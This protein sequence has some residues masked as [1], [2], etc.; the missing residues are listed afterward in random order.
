M[1]FRRRF[2]FPLFIG[3]LLFTVS[4]DAL[5]IFGGGP[6]CTLMGCSEGIN[7]VLTGEVPE[8]YFINTGLTEANA[9]LP[10][11]RQILSCKL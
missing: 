4:C 10:A 1:I 6:V 2:N 3:V 8:S 11:C 5:D 9:L 7:L